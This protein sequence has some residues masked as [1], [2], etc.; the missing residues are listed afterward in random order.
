MSTPLPFDANRG[1]TARALPCG[2]WTWK[3]STV[4][5]ATPFK[6]YPSRLRLDLCSPFAIIRSPIW[7]ILLTVQRATAPPPQL[8]KQESAYGCGTS[9]RAGCGSSRDAAGGRGWPLPRR[10]NHPVDPMH[11]V[12]IQATRFTGGA[13]VGHQPFRAA[14]RIFQQRPLCKNALRPDGSGIRCRSNRPQQRFHRQA[15]HGILR[16]DPNSSSSGM[17]GQLRLD[18]AL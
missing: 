17:S 16:R 14:S 18:C 2:A 5:P 1:A 9:D 12:Y 4:K 11:R 15:I 3:R 10:H 8:F 7:I 6:V 13:C